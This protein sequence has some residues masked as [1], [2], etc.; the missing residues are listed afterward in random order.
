MKQTLDSD[1]TSEKGIGTGVI[2]ESALNP[3]IQ[4]KVMQL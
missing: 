3:P 1:L 2:I 4:V